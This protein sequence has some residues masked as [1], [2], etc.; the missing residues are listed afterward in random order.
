MLTTKADHNGT[1]HE[2]VPADADE[3]LSQVNDG[4]A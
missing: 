3:A 2:P 4:R 1:G